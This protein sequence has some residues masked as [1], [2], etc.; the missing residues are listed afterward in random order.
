MT[1]ISKYSYGNVQTL[2]TLLQRIGDDYRRRRGLCRGLKKFIVAS[3]RSVYGEGQNVCG[4]CG[5]VWPPARTARTAP[6]R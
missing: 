2:A 3:S 1:D 6:T 5:P 4:R